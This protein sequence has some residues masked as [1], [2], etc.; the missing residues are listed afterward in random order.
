MSNKCVICQGDPDST[1][2]I[3]VEL[4]KKLLNRETIGPVC[5][6][7]SEIFFKKL[8]FYEVV[9]TATEKELEEFNDR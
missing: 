3:T 6:A 5:N 1:G 2:N 7:C 8:N 9:K 4:M